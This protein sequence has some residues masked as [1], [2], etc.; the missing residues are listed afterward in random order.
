MKKYVLIG[1]VALAILI[2]CLLRP[3]REHLDVQ[4]SDDPQMRLKQAQS[5]VGQINDRLSVMEAKIEE[6]E[7]KRGESTGE[8]TNALGSS[9]GKLS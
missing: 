5:K 4:N 2:V 9:S 7:S 3:R 1:F 8:A 6:S